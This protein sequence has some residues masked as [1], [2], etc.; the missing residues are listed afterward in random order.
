MTP[1]PRVSAQQPQ[2][3]RADAFTTA[4]IAQSVAGSKLLR[5]SQRD[6]VL[7]SPPPDWTAR[8]EPVQAKIQVRQSSTKREVLEPFSERSMRMRPANAQACLLAPRPTAANH[9]ASGH[10]DHV[11][12][13]LSPQ[14]TR[15]IYL[16]LMDT[17][18]NNVNVHYDF[19]GLFDV[20]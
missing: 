1:K 15:A 4:A 11:K 18:F 5:W 17:S 9:S 10:Q 13:W 2:S 16:N 14:V 12:V 7:A 19:I 20:Y 3:H 8:T 6:L